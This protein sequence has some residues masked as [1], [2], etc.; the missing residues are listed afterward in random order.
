VEESTVS[1]PSPPVFVLV[2]TCTGNPAL[3][4][5]TLIVT[6]SP[7]PPSLTAVS[8]IEDGVAASVAVLLGSVDPPAI[9]RAIARTR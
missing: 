5:F 3:E 8:E 6:G 7:A 1:Q 2:L 9:P 4:L